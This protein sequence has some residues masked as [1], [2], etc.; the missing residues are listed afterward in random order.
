MGI[1]F[2]IVCVCVV[3]I[4]V[5]LVC[6]GSLGHENAK[7]RLSNRAQELKRWTL[8]DEK[9]ALAKIR[10]RLLM[11]HK[12]TTKELIALREQVAIAL[13]SGLKTGDVVL[14][15]KQAMIEAGKILQVYVDFPPKEKESNQRAVLWKEGIELDEG[16][17]EPVVPLQEF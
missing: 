13:E 12:E 8:N 17:S 4:V 15:L 1:F 11:Q 16:P 5:L 9:I 2:G 3:L 7:L 6:I 10:D 14:N